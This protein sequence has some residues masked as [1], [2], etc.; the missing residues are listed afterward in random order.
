MPGLMARKLWTRTR[1]Y[2]VW[3]RI[4]NSV[5]LMLN[6]LVSMGRRNVQLPCDSQQYWCSVVTPQKDGQKRPLS[7]IINTPELPSRPNLQTMTVIVTFV[8]IL[9]T[10]AIPFFV[11]FC[12]FGIFLYGHFNKF[13]CCN[14]LVSKFMFQSLYFCFA[15]VVFCCSEFAKS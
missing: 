13:L 12:K 14:P 2:R 7:S 8:S 11:Q 5:Y 4:L 10:L 3:L 15:S 9:T 1:V 6:I